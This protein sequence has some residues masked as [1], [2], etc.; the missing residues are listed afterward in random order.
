MEPKTYRKLLG[1]IALEG[2]MECL[3]GLHI[4]ASKENLEIGSLDSPVVRDPIT[5]EPYVPGSSLKGKLRS[6]LEKANPDLLPNRRGGI[7]ISRH[8][9]DDWDAG[10]SQNKNY[11]NVF[12][13]PGALECPVCRLFGSTGPGENNRNFP[14]R[15]KVRDMRLTRESR[16][17]LETID[18]GLLF[19]EWKF[20]NSI[21]RLTSAANPRNLERVPR[22]TTFDFSIVYD[23]EDT[24][25]LTADLKNLQL[26]LLLLQDDAL[27]GHGSRGYGH[28]HFQFTKIEARKIDYYRGKDNQTKAVPGLE[29]LAELAKF[30]QNGSGG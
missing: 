20:E 17:K 16:E 28:V 8:E 25:T 19:T 10:Q 4:G 23:V 2:V 18:T 12:P 13:Y 21:D 26:A 22:G 15:L 5:S 11:K 24:D 9:C 6:L 14:A 29:D 1:K 30:F 27:G 3:S 7:G